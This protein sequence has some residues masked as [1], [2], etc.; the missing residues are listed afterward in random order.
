MKTMKNL[1]FL[2]FILA[3]LLLN[4]CQ[5]EEIQIIDNTPQQAIVANSTIVDL[6]SRTTTNDGSSDNIIDNASCLNIE[7]PVTVIVNGLEITI[8]SESD[9]DT[10]ESIFDELDD[11]DDS[12]NIIF[13]ITII[14][15]NYDEIII[16]NQDQLENLIDSCGGE[17]E[18]DDDIE[19]VDFVYPLTYSIFD[20][21][22]NTISTVTI[23]SDEDMYHFI[24]EID[25]EDIIALNFPITLIFSDGEQVTANSIQDLENIL[26]SAVNFCDED[27]DNDYGDDDFNLD[28]LNEL[29]VECPWIVHS[30]HRNNDNISD[31]YVDYALQFEANG[32]VKIRRRN[33][34]VVEGTWTTSES[35]NGI[36]LTLNVE[37]LN[38]F[39]LEWF[40][41]KLEDD[42]I[43]LHNGNG[44]RIILRQN[45]D[46]NFDNNID[47][48]ENILKECIWRIHDLEVN[49]VHHEEQYI[50]TPLKFEDNNIVKLRVNG[51]YVQGT[52]GIIESGS[53]FALK[54]S[55]D[56]RPELNLSWFIT[57]LENDKI[58]LENQN[59]EM[60]LKRVCSDTDDDVQF[61]NE[62]LI[63]GTWI[64]TYAE[65]DGINETTNY[66][67]FILD[68]LV[69]RRVH[70]TGNLQNFDGSWM[71]YRNDDNQLKLGLNFHENDP[72]SELNNRWRIIEIT[73]T[74]IELVDYSSTGEIEKKVVFEKQ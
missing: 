18:E 26:E 71:A 39:T 66:N 12:L 31:I 43:E 33:G 48:I 11:D 7:L 9:F 23:N 6:I 58:E 63:D 52:W 51:E 68:F 10:I 38:D 17:N 61:I 74:R 64:I 42:R 55:F 3:I 44:N 45:C 15:S 32:V 57:E 36:A 22:D 62:V 4:S 54:M 70:V 37:A 40:A 46:L 56:N 49:D 29:L 16:E 69:S 1:L 59:S 50:G 60:K 14:L 5:E 27:D 19:C 41:S 47:R 67:D 21:N 28:E 25:E 53:G 30:I 65:E 13:P 34:E 73:S 35:D 8:D 72:F 20:T 2:P 24:H